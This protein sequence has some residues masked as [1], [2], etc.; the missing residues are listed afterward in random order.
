M[1]AEE[2]T[3]Q[4]PA[5]PTTWKAGIEE[6]LREHEIIADKVT[7]L[8]GGT[9]CYL[10][11]L[12]GLNEANTSSSSRIVGGPVVLKCADAVAKGA[13][14]A[15]DESRLQAE[16]KALQSKPVAEACRSEP[17]VRVP[18]V[19]RETRNGFIMNWVGE[20]DL[21]TV[22][23]TA[24]EL[25]MAAIGTRLGKW[26]ACLHVAGVAIGP[27]GWNTHHDT[28]DKL[29]S[30][31]G[32]MEEQAARSVLSDSGEIERVLQIARTP[33]AVR[34]LTPWDFRPSNVVLTLPSEKGALPEMAVVDWELCYYG[35]PTNDI[36][37][38]V[39][40]AMM[41]EARHGDRG[42]LS[43]FLAAYKQH[44][45]SSIVDRAFVRKVAVSVGIFLLYFI[46]QGAAL[47]GFDEKDCLEWTQRA[48]QYLKAGAEEDVAWLAQ[49]VLKPLLD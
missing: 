14:I 25:D 6:Y 8:E 5:H 33:S 21:R 16:V 39:A 2:P 35:D 47:W 1:S 46:G 27:D 34:T 19:L 10:W 44:A 13:P 45:S 3:Q 9:S 17:S 42:L 22:Y 28:L 29:F 31:P 30:G 4:T 38:W 15:V 12:D 24:D 40:E 20:T 41:M 37:T 49:S 23:Q 36:R 48:V 11:K 26:L 7:P 43:S 32:G 18:S